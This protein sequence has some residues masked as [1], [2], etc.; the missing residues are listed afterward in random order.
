MD[1]PIVYTI[2]E[3]CAAGR[4]GRTSLYKAI[5]R[6][7]L[8]A[9]KRGRRTFILGSDLLPWLQKM[10]S[11]TRSAAKSV[12]GSNSVRDCSQEITV[13]SQPDE[14]EASRPPSLGRCEPMHTANTS[15]PVDK[16]VKA[17]GPHDDS[18]KRRT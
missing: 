18:S 2:A 11:L 5:G 4:V 6:G 1:A 17:R 7:E 9:V 10:P 14:R 15:P 16:A 8:R 12:D 3:A 13:V